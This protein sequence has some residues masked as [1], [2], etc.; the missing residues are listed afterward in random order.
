VRRELPFGANPKAPMTDADKT[1]YKTCPRC[2]G[3][4]SI[5]I[6]QADSPS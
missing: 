5:G 4:G 6:K 1:G 3:S 2:N